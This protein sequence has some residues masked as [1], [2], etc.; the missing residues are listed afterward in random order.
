MMICDECVRSETCLIY[1]QVV[2][3]DC[4]TKIVDIFQTR[5]WREFKEIDPNGFDREVLFK[6]IWKIFREEK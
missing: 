2:K 6:K 4:F 3:C 1:G 5:E